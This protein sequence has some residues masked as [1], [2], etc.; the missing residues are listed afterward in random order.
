[1]HLLAQ[2]PPGSIIRFEMVDIIEAED[3][4]MQ[5]CQY[6]LQLQN[7]CNLRLQEFFVGHALH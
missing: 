5:Q 4:F 7:A 3:I 1:M 6:L 2:L